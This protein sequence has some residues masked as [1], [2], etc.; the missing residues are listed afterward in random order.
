MDARVIQV[1]KDHPHPL[2]F[3]TVSGAHLY[4]FASDDSDVDIRGVHLLPCEAV[5]GLDQPEETISRIWDQDGLEL[6][7]VTHDAAKFFGMMLGRN[8]YVLEQLFSPLVL[9][10]G[11][12]H[13]ELKTLG[14]RCITRHHARHYLGFAA[15]QWKLF[16]KEK[17]QRAKPILYVFRVLFTG[18]HLM[19]TGEME[20]NL[21]TLNGDFGEPLLDELIAIKRGGAEKETIDAGF[22]ERLQTLKDRY[23]A[24]LEKAY[25]QSA[26]PEANTCRPDLNNLLL[27]LRRN[28]WREEG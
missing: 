23:E 9:H 5:L 24:E 10:G 3:A 17:E 28:H 2:L 12:V 18:I 21:A 22:L 4:G 11:Q 25:E 1:V 16:L 19:R 20:M 26:L 8:G 27:R 7:L 14:R 13:E 6:D 15:N